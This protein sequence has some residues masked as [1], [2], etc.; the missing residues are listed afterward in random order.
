MKYRP[1]LLCCLFLLNAGTV[2]AQVNEKAKAQEQ[3]EKERE[4][5]HKALVLVN[6]ITAATTSLKLPENRAYILAV[7]ADLMWD[8]DEKLARNLFWES[9]SNVNLI[10]AS[11]LSGS[12][13]QKATNE[14]IRDAHTTVHSVKREILRMVAR[15]DPQFALDLLSANRS[16]APEWVSQ[17]GFVDERDLEQQIATEAATRDPKRTL[18]AARESLAKRI[19]DELITF[20]F[21]LNSVDRE[22]GTK[23]AGEIIDKLHTENLADNRDAVQLAVVIIAT[24]REGARMAFGGVR[25]GQIML[26]DAQRRDVVELLVNAALA[27]TSKGEVFLSLGDIMTEVE[28]FIPNRVPSLKQKFA[29]ISLTLDKQQSAQNDYEV[30]VRSGNPETMLRGATSADEQQR[31][32]LEEQ[33]II[34]AVMQRRADSFRD[35]INKEVTDETR[36]NQLLDRLDSTA[37]SIA[38]S[39]GEDEA[40]QKMLPQIR[41]KEERAR[42]MAR[43]AILLE[44][45]GDHEK[46]LKYLEEA[47]SI[48]KIDVSDQAQ[49]QGVLD[50]L[51]AYALIEPGTAFMLFER[52]ID[53][54]NAEVSKAMLRDES[55]KSGLLRKGE[56]TLN[57]RSR[58]FIDSMLRMYGKALAA[59]AT[60]DLIRT[61][62]LADRFQR[63][64]LRLIARLYVAKSILKR[65]R[66]N[67]GR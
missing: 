9:I 59:L 2:L 57:P 49:M 33:A 35:F 16:A 37:I 28:Q 26:T 51:L 41:R 10:S 44:K 48:V 43:L 5:D 8:Q 62:S 56:I 42:A 4:L 11:M 27:I 1:L 18:Q 22:L 25:T 15:R 7:A 29:D 39:R 58:F 32:D 23:F 50:L 36:R 65:E 52:T 54:T 24:S 40:L 45:K 47:R 46:A 6:E 31:S 3:L 21:K 61:K 38:A 14:Q 67:T 66:P 19:G 30:L 53:L 12:S 55:A 64:E 63:N 17:Y 13:A 60:A 20:L 34:H